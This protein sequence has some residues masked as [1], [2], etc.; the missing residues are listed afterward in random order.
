MTQLLRANSLKKGVVWENIS[1][2]VW[3]RPSEERHKHSPT[4]SGVAG[5]AVAFTENSHSR[6]KFLFLSFYS[7][8]CFPVPKGNKLIVK[9]IPV[10]TKGINRSL[11]TPPPVMVK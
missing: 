10:K 1:L 6:L 8:L 9:P 3:T 5:R 2:Q 7:T 11:L 4:S